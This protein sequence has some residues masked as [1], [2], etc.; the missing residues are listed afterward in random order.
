MEK[1]DRSIITTA[2]PPPSLHHV[3]DV[4]EYSLKRK[5]KAQ[6]D[7]LCSI[8]RNSVMKWPPASKA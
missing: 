8:I 1:L 2:D 6:T 7:K 3:T 5:K 4:R